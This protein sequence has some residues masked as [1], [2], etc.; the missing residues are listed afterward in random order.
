M[1]NNDDKEFLNK[2]RGEF[3]IEAQELLNDCQAILE[4]MGEHNW[5]DFLAIYMANLHN[6][7]GSSKAAEFDLFSEV[8]HLMEEMRDDKI[9]HPRFQDISFKLL[10]A[11]SNSLEKMK[12]GEFDSSER[13]FKRILS[14]TKK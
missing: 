3:Y 9:S 6:V 8:I 4:N 7:K 12:K 10:S 13:L 5:D 14:T 2:L 11:L 1:T